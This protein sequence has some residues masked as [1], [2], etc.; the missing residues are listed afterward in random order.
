MSQ[1]V[2]R[3]APSPNGKLHLG[4]AYSALL[5]EKMARAAKGRLLLRLEDTDITRCSPALAKDMLDDLRWLGLQWE[6]PVRM[7]S[8]HFEDY[9]NALSKLLK[10][11]AIFPC[12]CS[13]KDAIHTALTAKDPDGQPHYGGPCANL[14][15]HKAHW[16]IEQNM[17]YGWRLRTTGTAAALWGDVMIAKPKTGS[18]YHIAVVV[19]DAIQSVTHVVRGRD[20][21]A[22]TAIHTLLQK[23]LELPTPHYHHHDLILDDA[24]QK[25]SKSL[26]SKSLSA[27]R[28]EGVTMQKLR[29]DL[30]FD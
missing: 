23:K 22:A 27:L 17:P 3:F 18:W 16:M 21:E 1:P 9:E 12:F 4:H 19:D 6:E 20:V 2:F 7:Q 26:K 14:A 30:G 5:N 10:D 25:L 29:A 15:P 13:R 28:A 11:D 8:Q 24:G